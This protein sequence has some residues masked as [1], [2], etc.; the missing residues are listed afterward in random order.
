M[1]VKSVTIEGMHNA[2][3]KHYDLGSLSYLYGKNGSGK[4]TVMQ[5][6]QLALLGYIPGTNKRTSDI[7]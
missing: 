2:T 3:R 6:V 7:F 1:E 5:A 4:T